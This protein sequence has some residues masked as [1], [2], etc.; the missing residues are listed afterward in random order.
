[1]KLPKQIPRPVVFLCL[2]AAIV[3]AGTASFHRSR[4][5]VENHIPEAPRFSMADLDAKARPFVEQANSAVP[6]V[7]ATP[8]P[9]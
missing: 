8:C 2:A 1:M 9:G 7:V 6:D 4:H 5:A 3:L